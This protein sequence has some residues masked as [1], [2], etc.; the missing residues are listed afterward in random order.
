MKIKL[1]LVLLLISAIFLVG[2]TAYALPVMWDVGI[3]GFAGTGYDADTQTGLF[4]QMGFASQTSTIQY[5][6]DGD[7]LLSVGDKFDDEG[8]IRI[9]TIMGQDWIDSEGLWLGGK[10]EITGGWNDIKGHVTDVDNSASTTDVTTR[11]TEGTI[12]I[13]FDENLDSAF[14]NVAGTSGIPTVGA[15]GTG[16]YDGTLIATLDV[17]DGIGHSHFSLIPGGGSEIHSQGSV[18][19]LLQFTYMLPGFWLDDLAQDL[20]VNPVTWHWALSDMN[21]DSPLIGEGSSEDELW[22][23]HSNQDGSIFIGRVVPEPGTILLLGMGLLG[24][25]IVGVRRKKS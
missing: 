10:Y 18:D 4:N 19:L 14:A 1:R 21:I 17:M 22:L 12:D 20:L 9:E 25:G 11:Y 16:F 24:M 7:L 15:G 6:T 2:S 13:Y 8:N 23:A 3:D 5:D